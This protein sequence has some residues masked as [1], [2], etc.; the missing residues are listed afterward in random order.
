[1]IA[2]HR[3]AVEMAQSELDAGENAEA[4]ELAEK[5]IADQEAEIAEMEGLLQGQ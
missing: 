3:G 2:H 5:I 1:M 4:L